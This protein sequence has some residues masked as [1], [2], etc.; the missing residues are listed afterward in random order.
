M[1]N[2]LGRFVD[3]KRV[4]S[5]SFKTSVNIVCDNFTCEQLYFDKWNL[6]R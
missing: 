5:P 4:E 6:P 1:K 2:G 3:E